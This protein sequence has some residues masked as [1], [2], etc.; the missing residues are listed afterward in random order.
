MLGMS[1]GI[2]GDL[3]RLTSMNKSVFWVQYVGKN[4]GIEAIT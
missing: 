1:R 2:H 3:L 4:T